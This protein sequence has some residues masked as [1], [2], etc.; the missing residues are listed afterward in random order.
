MDWA[1]FQPLVL[2]LVKTDRNMNTEK[3]HTAS[4]VKAYLDRNIHFIYIFYLFG[5][6]TKCIYL[7]ISVL[8]KIKKNW[9]V[10]VIS[11]MFFSEEMLSAP[12]DS[13]LSAEPCDVP[14]GPQTSNH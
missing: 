14:R 10:V 8:K 13:I 7:F 9:K 3:Y 1:A 4:A 11:M 2:G 12:E 5:C 6:F